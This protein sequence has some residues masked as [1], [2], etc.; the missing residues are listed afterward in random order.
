MIRN[1]IALLF[2]SLHISAIGMLLVYLDVVIVILKN[3]EINERIFYWYPYFIAHTE[4]ANSTEN[5]FI[6]TFFTW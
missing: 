6:F 1:M 5:R 3:A 4:W 2:F